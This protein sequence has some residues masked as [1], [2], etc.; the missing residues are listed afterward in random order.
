ME[1]VDREGLAVI[2]AFYEESAQASFTYALALTRCPA[3]AEDAVHDAVWPSA[4]AGVLRR[5]DDITSREIASG[6]AG[7]PEHGGVVVPPRPRQAA[8]KGV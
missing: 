6:E 3:S 8:R 7:A 4:E 5:V 1:P 2:R